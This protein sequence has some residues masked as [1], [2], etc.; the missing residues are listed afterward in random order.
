M[1]PKKLEQYKYFQPIA[2]TVCIG[3]AS[4]VGMLAL[5]VKDTVERMESSSLSFENRL[6]AVEQAVGG[7]E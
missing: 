7:G 2:W 1:Q 6:K 3:F 5:N 4:F